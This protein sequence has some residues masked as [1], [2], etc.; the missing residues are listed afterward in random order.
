MSCARS[1]PRGTTAPPQP[2]AAAA[3]L[4]SAGGT[5]GSWRGMVAWA[6]SRPNSSS[7]PCTLTA[8]PTSVPGTLGCAGG[9]SRCCG[10]VPAGLRGALEAERG[11]SD[12]GQPSSPPAPE[13]SMGLKT[14]EGLQSHKPSVSTRTRR[15]VQGTPPS[16][17]PPAAAGQGQNAGPGARRL[18]RALHRCLCPPQQGLTQA[19]QPW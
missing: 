3:P 11:G 15:P 4:R 8:R 9:S 7:T 6:G 14:T 19:A 2:V 1:Q 12:A 18:G 16:Q 13:S 17:V 10:F 5:A